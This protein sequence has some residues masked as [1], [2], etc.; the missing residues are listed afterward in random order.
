MKRTFGRAGWR[1]SLDWAGLSLALSC[2]GGRETRRQSGALGRAALPSRNSG[3]CGENIKA[4]YTFLNLP[5]WHK[6]Q[7]LLRCP[8]N[9]VDVLCLLTL[10]KTSRAPNNSIQIKQFIWWLM[11]KYDG[12]NLCLKES[13]QMKSS[14]DLQLLIVWSLRRGR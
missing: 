12:D 14:K 1:G 4:N 9:W 11:N 2:F 5:F 7:L 3:R 10:P 8:K 13:I 6:P